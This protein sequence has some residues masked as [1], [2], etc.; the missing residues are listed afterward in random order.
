MPIASR[1][2]NRNWHA[3]IVRCCMRM[4]LGLQ[5][6]AGHGLNYHNVGPIVAIP[7]IAELNIGHAIISE[8]VFIGLEQAVK[9]MKAL[10]AA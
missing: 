8:A 3:F 2:A 6:N 5:V 9:N 7:H 1:H 4:S 10:L